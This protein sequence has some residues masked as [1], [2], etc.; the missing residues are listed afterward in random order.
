MRI[1]GRRIDGGRRRLG[2]VLLGVLLAA[3]I[4]Y[5]RLTPPYSGRSVLLLVGG[6]LVLGAAVVLAWRRPLP[7]L[8]LVVLGSAVDGNFVFALPVFSYLVGRREARATPAAVVFAVLAVGGT[9][10]NLELFGARPRTWFL[11]ATVLIFG[12][13]F[14]WL[15]GR[16]LRQ[17][18][19]LL[20]AGW[21]QAES[22]RREQ[23][24]AAERVR[25]RERA[26]IARDMHDSLGHDLSLIALRAGVLELAGDLDPRH[27]A[28]VGELRAS[29]TAATARLG[30]IVRVLRTDAG[31]SPLDPV[32]DV[33]ALVAGARAAGMEVTLRGDP[34]DADLPALTGVAV[35]GLVREAL[36]NAARYAPG[37]PVTVSVRRDS[38]DVEVSVRNAPPPVPPPASVSAGTGLLALRER[39]RLAG[40]TLD[41]GPRDGGFVVAARLPGTPGAAGAA[42]AAEAATAPEV[43]TAPE[44]GTA[45]EP[46]TGPGA[47][48]APEPTAPPG[49]GTVLPGRLGD[50][51]RRVRRSLLVAV[52]APIALAGLLAFVYHPFVTADAVLESGAYERMRPGQLRSELVG[53]PRRQVEGPADAPTGCEYYTDGNFPLAQPAYRL[54]FAQGRLVE[55]ERM[56]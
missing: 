48:T 40:G 31:P 56:P 12:G 50:A 10:L 29:V 44:A 27:R 25:L 36:T 38:D 41:A 18:H 23:H 43:A 32:D 34:A 47:V 46:A 5:P 9:L 17:Q 20:L 16:Y 53:L 49:G 1:L 45:P 37:T 13:V 42:L 3:P 52:G 14:P 39:V 7:A 30:E 28:A 4:T 19:A 26:R 21:E 8:V 2:D 33:A 24:G 54:C 6:L 51:R 55:K 22:V 11:L 35:R 15:V